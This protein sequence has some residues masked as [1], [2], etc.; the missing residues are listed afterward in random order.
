[1]MAV[2]GYL[3]NRFGSRITLILSTVTYA[4]VLTSIPF[5]HDFAALFLT[6]LL[7]G[8]AANLV[9]IALNTQACALE[10]ISGRNIMSSFHGLWSL[11]GLSGGILGVLFIRSGVPIPVHYAGIAAL[12]LCM[13]L[14]GG[15]RLIADNRTSKPGDADTR[16]S[17]SL[18]GIDRTILL[19]GVIGFGGMFCEG[20]LF[21]WSGVYFATVVRPDEGLVRAGYIAGM[22]AMTLGRFLADGFVARYRA[23][24][25]LRG[26]GLLIT[27]G[28]LSAV[29]F[30]YLLTATLGFLLVGFGISSI[31]PICY[32]MAGR[33][34][35][36]SASIAIT[37]V[38]SVSFVGFMV[39]PPLIGLLSE[40]FDLRI[41]LGAASLFGLFIVLLAGRIK[42]NRRGGSNPSCDEIN[43]HQL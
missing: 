7:F 25:V 31:V 35:S 29:V 2:S 28:L 22:G 24:A 40:A 20:T 30:P 18:S 9:N 39:G 36:M 11:G 14:S 4:I 10:G 15:R 33:Q 1:M 3:V 32:S 26:C 41:A 13:A 21:D 38:S 43:Y 37:V 8:A 5:S 19:L 34:R 23:S 12:C 16:G 42:R 17:L 27:S 6:L